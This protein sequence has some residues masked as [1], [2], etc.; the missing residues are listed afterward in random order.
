MHKIPQLNYQNQIKFRYWYF[1]NSL[2][3]NIFGAKIQPNKMEYE[4]GVEI[5]PSSRK[6]D[7]VHR[8]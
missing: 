8:I 5:E 2:L 3:S 1:K 4:S 6:L 7:P